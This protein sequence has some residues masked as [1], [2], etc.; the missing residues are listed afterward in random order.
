MRT[1]NFDVVVVGFGNAAQAAAYSARQTGAKTLII[2]KAPEKKRGG[3]TR[4]SA[5]AHLRH[6]HN[7]LPEEI[8]L[9]PHIPKSEFDRV[10]LEPYSKDDFYADLMRV[11]RG[12]SVPELAE[13]LVSES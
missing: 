4:F 13:L 8:A 11:T 10:D 12:R 6:V 5:S 3:N 2:E 7:G 1:E 9:L